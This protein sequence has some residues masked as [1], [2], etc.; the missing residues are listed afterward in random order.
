MMPAYN[1]FT[2]MK[3]LRVTLHIIGCLW[4]LKA[5][6]VAIFT[7]LLLPVTVAVVAAIRWMDPEFFP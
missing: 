3:S 6:R 5:W 7:T 2:D 1:S 4:Q